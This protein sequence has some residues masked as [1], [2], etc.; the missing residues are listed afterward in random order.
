MEKVLSSQEQSEL[1][2]IKALIKT[3]YKEVNNN[4]PEDASEPR[5]ESFDL[6]KTHLKTALLFVEDGLKH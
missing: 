5:K 6:A 4:L 1:G 2:K 3:I